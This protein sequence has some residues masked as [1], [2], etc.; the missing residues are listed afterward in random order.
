MSDL[1]VIMGA[2]QVHG[3]MELYLRQLAEAG[4]D[5]HV[6]D[7]S[8][9]PNMNGGGNLGYRVKI[10]RELAQAF[11]N[12]EFIVFSDAFDVTFYGTKEEVLDSVPR[13]GLL[14]AA[15]KNCYP[16]PAIAARIKN[17]SPWRFANGGLVAGSPE[18]YLDWCEEVVKCPGYDPEM[19]DQRMLNMLVA[20][21]SDLCVIDDSTELFFCLFG[22]Y[23]ELEFEC[24]KP[25]NTMYGTHPSFLHSNGK[26]DATEMWEKYERSL[27]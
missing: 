15:E 6:A 19:L 12:Y 2:S 7:V 4:I 9:R 10:F 27:Q 23:P 11:S 16:D 3:T 14:H 20:D 26:W 18:S 25:V 21:D 5:T 17:D 24:G 13:Y 1:I 22:G 8:D